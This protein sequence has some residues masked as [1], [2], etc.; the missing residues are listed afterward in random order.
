MMAINMLKSR[1][2]SESFPQ[3]ICVKKTIESLIEF[4][5]C[6]LKVHQAVVFVP[7]IIHHVKL[8]K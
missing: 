7:L 3:E 1:V 2:L 4:K 8:E 6:Y 5:S